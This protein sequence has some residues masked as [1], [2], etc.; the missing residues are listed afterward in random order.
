L[1]PCLRAGFELAGFN[2][3]GQVCRPRRGVGEVDGVDAADLVGD[4]GV[5][6]RVQIPVR[7]VE[8]GVDGVAAD[9]D[10]FDVQGLRDA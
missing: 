2:V 6:E 1:H 4:A 7:A 3:G 10:R 9:R 8:S 5:P